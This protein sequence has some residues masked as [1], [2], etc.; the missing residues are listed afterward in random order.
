MCSLWV[1]GDFYSGILCVQPQLLEAI[2]T[3]TAC[4]TFCRLPIMLV[5]GAE[6]GAAVFRS[7][8]GGADMYLESRQGCKLQSGA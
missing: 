4:A 6:N 5:I 8:N 3:P 2:L 1:K 7:D